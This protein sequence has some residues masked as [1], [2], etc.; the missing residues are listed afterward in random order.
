MAGGRLETLA[1]LLAEYEALDGPRTADQLGRS[2]DNLLLCAPGDP[3][4]DGR[5]TRYEPWSTDGVEGRTFRPAGRSVAGMRLPARGAE[6][7]LAVGAEGVT[8]RSAEGNA[9]TVRFADCVAYRHWQDDIRELRGADGFRIRIQPTEWH[10]GVEA[11]RALDAAIP[12]EVVVCDEHGVGAY[13]DSADHPRAGEAG[14][15]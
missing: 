12:P 9:L 11:V 8:W 1:D 14:Q 2:L 5:W 15:G 4:A 13:E 10:Q 6:P 3:P 7:T